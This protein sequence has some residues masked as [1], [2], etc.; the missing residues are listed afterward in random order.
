[1]VPH[2]VPLEMY[3]RGLI[4]QFSGVTKHFAQEPWQT[5]EGRKN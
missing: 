3:M 4:V 2:G 5:L 1:M